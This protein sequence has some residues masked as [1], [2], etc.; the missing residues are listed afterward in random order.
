ML[1]F[2]ILLGF[3]VAGGAVALLAGPLPMLARKGGRLHRRAGDVYAGAMIVTAASALVL[4]AVTANALLL[5]FA[6]FAFF[7]VFGGVRAIGFR[8]G[9]RPSRVDDA[10]VVLTAVFSLGLFARGVWTADI[11]SLFFGVLGSLLALREWRRLRDPGTDWL[12]AHLTS[13]G[14]AYIATATA[15]LAVNLAFLPQALV[16]VGP[17]LLGLPLLFRAASRHAR[18]VAGKRLA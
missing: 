17:T 12:V 15:F 9:R 13:M 10:V 11:T 8:R 4:A 2:D 16:F 7:L 14:A 18:P 6:V 3:H 5:M 1:L